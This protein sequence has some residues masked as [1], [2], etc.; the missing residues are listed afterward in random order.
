MNCKLF[1][2]L[3][4]AIF[5]RYF[6]LGIL[7]GVGNTF[8]FNYNLYIGISVLVAQLCV[9]PYIIINHTDNENMKASDKMIFICLSMLISTNIAKSF[10]DGETIQGI[11]FIVLYFMLFAVLL[12]IGYCIIEHRR[13]LEQEEQESLIV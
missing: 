2:T 3:L 13:V 11:I 12:L 9:I 4:T 5:G 8:L 10:I 6:W 1:Y 7:L